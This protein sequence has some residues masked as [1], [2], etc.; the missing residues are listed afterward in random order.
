M[1]SNVQTNLVS[2]SGPRCQ[3]SEI[4]AFGFINNGIFQNQL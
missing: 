1:T 4:F 2:Q 3:L